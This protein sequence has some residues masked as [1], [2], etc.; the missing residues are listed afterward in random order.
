M[1]EAPTPEAIGF[2]AEIRQLL[3]ILVHS[4]YTD[5]EIFLR[6]LISNAS[7]ALNRLQFV[8]LTERDMLDPQAELAVRIKGDP[9]KRQLTIAD[10]GIGM[11]RDELIENLGTI[12]HSGAKAF[13]QSLQ[14]GQKVSDLI[15]QF[16]VGFYS[17]FMVADSV[18]VTSRSY[19]PGAPAW[20]WA[21]T[22]G[23]SF[24]LEP[25]GKADRGT[26]VEITL[27]ED[28]KEFT[29]AWRL[30][31]I[32]HKHSDFVSFP[33]Y[34]NDEAEAVNRQTAV[35]RQPASAVTDEAANSFYKQ[36]T[37]DFDDPLARI[38]LQTDAPVQIYALLFLPA[39]TERGMFS[40]RRDYGLKLYSRK[41]LIQ[42]YAKDLLP[43]YLRFVEGVVESEDVPLNISRETIQSSRVI[44]RIRNALTHKV[45]D[46]LKDLAAGDPAKYEAFWK[47]FSPYMKEGMATDATARER[48]MP[49]LRFY[50]SRPDGGQA[51]TS[52]AEYVGRLKPDQRTIYYILGDDV[53]SV[54]HSP[55]LD[56]F[57]KAGLEVLYLVDPLDSFMLAGLQTY[58]G[59]PLKNVDDPSLDLPRPAEPAAGESA[60][61]DEFAALVARAR[62]TLGERV[63]DVRASDRLVDNPSRL[64]AADSSREHEM[65]RVRRML[66]RDFTVPKMVMELN[67]QHPLIRNLARLAAQNQTGAVVDACIEQMYENGLLTEGLLANPANMVG[68]IQELMLAATSGK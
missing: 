26:V 31:E 8:M 67:R 62:G 23:E 39:K 27:K 54:A 45:I 33:I 65:G 18:R 25:A 50:S 9:E 36:L 61:E 6:E 4:L 44:E 12:A 17:V 41:I 11:T 16:G 10:T 58:E 28:A 22:G 2:R 5:R 40:L 47:E 66:D 38:Q 7:D 37:L 21:S 59:F 13:L 43:K 34:A 55:H 35:W 24:T 19:R 1:T 60:P 14:E 64:V 46:T 68:R 53:R 56:Y 29:D 42:D 51:L 49:L 52:L 63:T 48:L 3:N 20:T 57:R 32:I 15:G 30:K